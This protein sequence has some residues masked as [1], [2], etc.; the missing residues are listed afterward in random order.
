MNAESKTVTKHTSARIVIVGGGIAGLATAVRVAQAGFPVTVLEASR[1]G[2]GASTRNQGWLHSGAWFAPQRPQLAQICYES[3]Q[4]TLRFCPECVEENPAPMIYMTSQAETDSD[5]WTAA[6]DIADIPYESVSSKELFERIPGLAISQ[7]QDAFQL[8][9]RSMRTDLLLDRLA[10]TAENA[11]VEIRPGSFV[12][13][14][15]YRGESVK[16]VE[17]STGETI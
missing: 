16:G 2:G 3:L 14:L 7:A 12:S 4:Q 10:E 9:D 11:G 8:P 5:R 17:L 6:W 1:I 15:L 13:R